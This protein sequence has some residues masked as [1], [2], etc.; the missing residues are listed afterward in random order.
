[1]AAFKIA[2]WSEESAAGHAALGE[3]YRQAKDLAG[4]RLEAERA[5]ALAPDLPEAR[6]C[7]SA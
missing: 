2:L 1:M 3:A 5:L 6:R 7:S 4:A